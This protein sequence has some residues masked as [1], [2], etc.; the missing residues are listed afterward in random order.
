MV[1]QRINP[2]PNRVQ[3]KHQKHGREYKRAWGLRPLRL[4]TLCTTH[5]INKSHLTLRVSLLPT[6]L[7]Y[8]EGA[9]DHA[10]LPIF[11]D[12]V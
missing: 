4:L 7:I 10:A 12:H 5:S 1:H 3:G 2:A 9:E 6:M 8:R 11:A